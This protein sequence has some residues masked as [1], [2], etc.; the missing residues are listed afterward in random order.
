MAKKKKLSERQRKILQALEDLAQNLGLRVSYGDLRFAGLKLKGGQC[1]FRGEKWL[2]MDRRQ[3]YEEQVDAFV[4]ALKEF[5]I[6]DQEI[7]VVIKGL[8]APS[9]LA[10]EAAPADH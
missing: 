10:V 9:G 3:P 7:P 1:L 4:D 5:D 8:F 2:V 6:E